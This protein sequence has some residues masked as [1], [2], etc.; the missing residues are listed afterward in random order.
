[1]QPFSDACFLICRLRVDCFIPSKFLLFHWLIYPC[2][3]YMRYKYPV[4]KIRSVLFDVSQLELGFMKGIDGYFCKECIDKYN[5]KPVRENY[6]I[7]GFY[8]CCLFA[9]QQNN[10][11]CPASVHCY[12]CLCRRRCSRPALRRHE[13]L[14]TLLLLLIFFCNTCNIYMFSPAK[15]KVKRGQFVGPIQSSRHQG[16]KILPIQ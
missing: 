6:F 12:S 15:N 8:P 1:M 10:S 9:Y 11:T 3:L 14:Q 7:R 13:N 2:T 16:P 4:C 5:F